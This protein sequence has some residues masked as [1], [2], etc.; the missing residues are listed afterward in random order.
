M[1]VTERYRALPRN[2]TPNVTRYPPLRGN[3]NGNR[4][5]DVQSEKRYPSGH[6]PSWRQRARA[7]KL[8]RIRDARAALGRMLRRDR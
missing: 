8:Q 5:G 6:H 4:P 1:N 7:E 2:V 3:G